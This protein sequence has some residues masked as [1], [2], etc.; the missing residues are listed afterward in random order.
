MSIRRVT[1]TEA[2][3]VRADD[4]AMQ[5]TVMKGDW[6]TVGDRG[7]DVSALQRGLKAAGLFSGRVDGKFGAPLKA[8]VENFQ[9]QK[10]LVVDGEVGPQT[11]GALKKNELF[12]GDHFAQPA[13]LGQSGKDILGIEKKMHAM[14]IDTGKVD[15]VFD[16]KTLSA[17]RGLRKK[18]PE[19]KDE[20]QDITKRFESQLDKRAAFREANGITAPVKLPVVK[21]TVADT[22]KNFDTQAPKGGLSP[23]PFRGVTMNERTVNMIE[24]AEFVM[25]K[26]LGHPGFQFNITQGSFSSSVSA[27]AGTHD[28][29]GALDV[30]TSSL[31]K[32]TVDDMVKSLRQAGFAAWSRGRGFDSFTPHIHAIAIGDSSASSGAKSQVQE[33]GRGGDGLV[34]SQLDPDRGLGRPTP[35]WAKRFL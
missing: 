7:P 10:G 19:L 33:F 15:G 13:Q 20:R 18:D 24:R 17:V 26:K 25:Q 35:T 2:P 29:G 14:G 21:D 8:A 22:L 31:P 9:Q 28:R 6:M 30:H 1:P 23:I 34:G 3:A 5:K 32:K 16:Q 11:L 12:V 27:S 4:A